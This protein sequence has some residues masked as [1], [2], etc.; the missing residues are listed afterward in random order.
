MKT[1]CTFTPIL[2]ISKKVSQDIVP[3]RFVNYAGQLAS[4]GEKALGVS[5]DTWLSASTASLVAIGTAVLETSG[6]VAIGN[7]ISADTNG[8][9]KVTS[10]TEE[11]NG[12]AITGCTGAGMISI[13]LT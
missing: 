13:L 8:K 6:T 7:K 5:E 12:Y 10:S 11:V 3:Y 2:Q 9:A 4:T 1:K